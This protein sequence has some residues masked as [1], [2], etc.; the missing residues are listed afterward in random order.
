MPISQ[1]TVLVLLG[2]LADLAELNDKTLQT[3]LQ[4]DL[5]Q[6]GT[7]DA[8]TQLNA[9]RRLDM[10]ARKAHLEAISA[11]M[12]DDATI[13]INPLTGRAE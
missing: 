5:W 6:P 12:A 3:A 7:Q 1:K 13:E 9:L 8:L 10:A 11:I 4:G 2:L